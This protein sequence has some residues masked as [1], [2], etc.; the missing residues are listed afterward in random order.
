MAIK[1]NRGDG[2]KRGGFECARGQTRGEDGEACGLKIAEEEMGALRAEF[3]APKQSAHVNR[4]VFDRGE[5]DVG[6]VAEVEF[7]IAGEGEAA[8]V[9]FQ[10]EP[11]GLAAT[12]AGG[13]DAA[14]VGG[15]VGDAGA[16]A[17]V[18]ARGDEGLGQ[19]VV[20]RVTAEAEGG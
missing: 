19:A 18:A 8:G 9:N 6:E 1:T 12:P 3:A 20:E 16:G 10:A 17:Q 7:E 4:A 15:G 14:G 2:A 5:A 13:P 11:G